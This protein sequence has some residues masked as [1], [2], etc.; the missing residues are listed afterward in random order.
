[1]FTNDFKTG[2]NSTCYDELPVTDEL[3]GNL[4][5]ECRGREILILNSTE[6]K[7]NDGEESKETTKSNFLHIIFCT[8]RLGTLL[9][10][11]NLQSEVIE[12]RC[13]A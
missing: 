1:M 3:P 4:R 11:V 5:N 9:T 10:L 12:V 8:A 13:T 2:D 7:D 6:C